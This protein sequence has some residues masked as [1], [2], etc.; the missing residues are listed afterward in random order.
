VF[1]ELDRRAEFGDF[2]GLIRV[3]RA[4]LDDAEAAATL[5]LHHYLSWAHFQLD[6]FADALEHGHAA[7]DPLDEAKALFHLWRFDEMRAALAECGDEAE[8]HW[9]RALLAEF[10]GE[11]F[12]EHL[13][14]AIELE[15]SQ[16]HTPVRL[17]SDAIDNVV[18]QALGTLPDT[19]SWIAQEAVVEVRPL[20]APHPDVDPLTLGLYVGDDIAHRSHADGVRLPPK[21]EI[22]QS[23]IERMATS[24]E[25]AI[26]EVRIT[27]LHEF[28]HHFGFDEQDMER[29]GLD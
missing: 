19:L 22:Y 14:R 2:E 13:R 3:A 21:I 5:D 28:G 25:H 6:R 20:P 8:A 23:N 27:L 7:Q 29:L 24:T 1:E 18:T 4:A 10:T 16:F 9:Y 15:P 17:D 11:E 12:R 26:E